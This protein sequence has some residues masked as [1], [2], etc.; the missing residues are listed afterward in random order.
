MT[1][2]QL[3]L[4]NCFKMWRGIEYWPEMVILLIGGQMQPHPTVKE[5]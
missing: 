4:L 3:E 2:L 1:T 5:L